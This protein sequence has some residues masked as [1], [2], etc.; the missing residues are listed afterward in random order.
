MSHD[1]RRAGKKKETSEPKRGSCPRKNGEHSW[2]VSLHYSKGGAA[3]LVGAGEGREESDRM[4]ASDAR[5]RLLW[6]EN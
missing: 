6:G 2:S 5:R 4:R 1:G 3:S